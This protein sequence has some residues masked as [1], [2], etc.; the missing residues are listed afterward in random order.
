[1]AHGSTF[2]DHDIGRPTNRDPARSGSPVPIIHS[3]SVTWQS[4]YQPAMTHPPIPRPIPATPT[5]QAH[6]VLTNPVSLVTVVIVQPSPPSRRSSQ[7]QQY[8][9]WTWVTL[10][11][12]AFQ[13]PVSSSLPFHFHQPRGNI[14]GLS[15]STS[16]PFLPSARVTFRIRAIPINLAFQSTVL[17]HFVIQMLIDCH[18]FRTTTPGICISS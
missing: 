8:A 15:I 12:L 7:S 3:F 17:T 16:C 11:N 10:A 14:Y 1:M 6:M 4:R 9:G 13:H 5:C 2:P 18:D